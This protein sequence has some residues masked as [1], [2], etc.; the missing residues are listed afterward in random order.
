M[1]LKN[2]FQRDKLKINSKR[3]LRNFFPL[4]D[5]LKW[6]SASATIPLN[7]F[8]EYSTK[9]VLV[10]EFFRLSNN[11]LNSTFPDDYYAMMQGS[12]LL[13]ASF[14][15]A[16]KA[17]N[18]PSHKE[19]KKL[20]RSKLDLAVNP[21]SKINYALLLPSLAFSSELFLHNPNVDFFKNASTYKVAFKASELA[22]VIFSVTNMLYGL[23][24][25]WSIKFKTDFKTFK[26]EILS[27][28][29]DVQK[30][31]LIN[32]NKGLIEFLSF[33]DLLKKDPISLDKLLFDRLVYDRVPIADFNL[34]QAY[35]FLDSSKFDFFVYNQQVR[36]YPDKKKITDK[37]F[38]ILSKDSTLDSG[39]KL[40][41]AWYVYLN[42]I[43]DYDRLFSEVVSEELI[44]SPLKKVYESTDVIKTF[45]KEFSIGA[46]RILVK[47][48]F[49]KDSF[50]KEYLMSKI[51]ETFFFERDDL[52]HVPVFGFKNE[53]DYA[54]FSMVRPDADVAYG[55]IEK[56]PKEKLPWLFSSLFDLWN[57]LSSEFSS[58]SE[59][60]LEVVDLYKKLLAKPIVKSKNY[61]S[62]VND[63]IDILNDFD[64][65]R[66]GLDFHLEN[67]LLKEFLNK[68]FFGKIDHAYKGIL[69]AIFDT[70]N[71]YHYAFD[72]LDFPTMVNL[73]NEAVSKYSTTFEVSPEQSIIRQAA[74]LAYR[75]DAFFKAW[76]KSDSRQGRLEDLLKYAPAMFD[77]MKKQIP[78]SL[79]SWLDAETDLSY[80]FLKI[81]G[82]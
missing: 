28:K 40:Y 43:P 46:S 5:I 57:D 2:S 15:L 18:F 71:L 78:N 49:D 73:M 6:Y 45:S 10:E 61:E 13:V 63:R 1:D 9:T 25:S 52:L 64:D 58:H 50:F 53:K 51:A 68:Y 47:Q 33:R 23:A 38:N 66:P 80:Q 60:S 76:T 41:L 31:D 21:V 56:F 14:Y 3:F 82:R 75:R 48:S 29:K 42:K 69:P 55:I 20:I 44:K 39:K 70:V 34:K 16:S 12:S 24:N 65:L 4:D 19:F 26:R 35:L 74:G 62:V 30:N 54:L 7:K 8:I 11:F 32:I 59:L 77:E 67:I 81:I 37:L 17:F 72:K 36:D 22:F 79:H 27:S